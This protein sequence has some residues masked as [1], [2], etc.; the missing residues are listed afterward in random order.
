ML[1]APVPGRKC[2]YWATAA[3]PCSLP[4]P[5][6]PGPPPSLVRPPFCRFPST[7]LYKGS[8]ALVQMQSVD[9]A[10]ASIQTLNGSFPRGASQP[11][12]VRYADSPGARSA[13]QPV[14]SRQLLLS[15]PHVPA[16]SIL[17]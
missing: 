12:L 4:L 5:E 3:A 9:Q 14:P 15:Q 1:L 10:A 7:E 11:L 13:L 6:S 17:C 8:G 16:V 2:F